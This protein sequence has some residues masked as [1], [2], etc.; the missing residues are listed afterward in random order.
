MKHI[1]IAGAAVLGVLY[2]V[3]RNQ[4]SAG[5]DKSAGAGKVAAGTV[6]APAPTVTPI[7]KSGGSKPL[8][9]CCAGCAGTAASPPI[10]D[11]TP[12]GGLD[13]PTS[14]RTAPKAF[15][16]LGLEDLPGDT[17]SA[18]ANQVLASGGTWFGLRTAGCA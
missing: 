1:L 16:D 8:G 2:L 3:R 6:D 5:A 9:A 12:T 17:R 13:G 18:P 7:D 15:E 4:L 14:F 10:I 11:R